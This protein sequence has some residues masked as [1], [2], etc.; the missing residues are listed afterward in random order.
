MIFIV[1]G[2]CIIIFLLVGFFAPEILVSWGASWSPS[3]PAKGFL[4]SVV[5]LVAAFMFLYAVIPLLRYWYRK[6]WKG[7]G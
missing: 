2:I 3:N 4:E 7:Y 6:L 5:I 1:V